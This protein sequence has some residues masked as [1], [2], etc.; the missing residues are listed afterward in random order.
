MLKKMTMLAMAVG[1]LAALALPAAASATWKHGH[2]TAIQNNV[3]LSLT[4]Q[5]TFQSPLGGIRCQVTSDVIFKAG[6]TTGT[7]E[8]FLTDPAGSDTNACEGTG[9]LSPCEVHDVTPQTGLNWVLHTRSSPSRIE[10]TTGQLT[11]QTTGA[12]CLV[13]HVVLDAGTVTATPDQETLTGAVNLSGSLPATIKTHNGTV[14]T[15]TAQVHN[16]AGG[17]VIEPPNKNTYS[18]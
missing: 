8:S 12:F 13:T 16:Q 3:T 5:A 1:L 11:S 18:I 10:I 2:S 17:L 4:G 7:V 9:G 15:A 6:Q 14:H